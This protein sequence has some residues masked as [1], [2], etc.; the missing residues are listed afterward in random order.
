M[1]SGYIDQLKAW[2]GLRT[3][4]LL[5]Q[6]SNHAVVCLDLS[7]EGN[8][9]DPSITAVSLPEFGVRQFLRIMINLIRTTTN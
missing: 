9:T 5:I 4:H 1:T 3:P 7:N 2:I 8:S 6:H